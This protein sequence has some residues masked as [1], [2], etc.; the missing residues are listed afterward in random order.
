MANDLS[1]NDADRLKAQAREV[2]VTHH[3]DDLETERA[4][5]QL[6]Q[7]ITSAAGQ[8]SDEDRR[9]LAHFIERLIGAVWSDTMTVDEAC[10]K[11]EDVAAAAA[12]NSEGFRRLIAN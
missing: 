10:S 12:V 11:I 6:E 8:L 2:L 3:A 7:I 5:D 4:R 9:A 1:R